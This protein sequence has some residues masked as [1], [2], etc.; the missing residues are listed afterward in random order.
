MKIAFKTI[1]Y[2]LLFLIFAPVAKSQDKGFDKA[3]FYKVMEN[4]D[5]AA[6][7]KQLKIIETADINK[8][9]YGGA[10]EMKRAGLVKG[11]SKK[12]NVFKAGHKKLEAAIE[13]DKANVE[14]HFLR[15]IIQEHAPKILGYRDDIDKDAALVHGSFK[16]LSP[17]LQAAVMDYRKQSNTLQKL[18][19]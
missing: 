5:L 9:A 8:E 6:V 2:S 13:K 1:I 4:G 19:F 16:K 7:D 11:P 17:E 3:A 18:N 12:L 15:L 10:M 14:W